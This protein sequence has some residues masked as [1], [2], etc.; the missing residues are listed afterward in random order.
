MKK[1][2]ILKILADEYIQRDEEK[3]NNFN[4]CIKNW[5]EYKEIYIK[6]F[7]NMNKDFFKYDFDLNSTDEKMKLWSEHFYELVCFL[8]E[9]LISSSPDLYLLFV[10]E[11]DEGYACANFCTYV[12]RDNLADIRKGINKIVN[13]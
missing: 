9:D 4:K 7:L 12:L 11:K 1:Q 13:K 2:N 5:N 3:K 10:N 6:S 8:F